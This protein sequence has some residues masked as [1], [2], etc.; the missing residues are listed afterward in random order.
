MMASSMHPFTQ[1]LVLLPLAAALTLGCEASSPSGATPASEGTKPS[2]L[3]ASGAT[4]KAA[5]P[6]PSAGERQAAS[7]PT[8]PGHAASAPGQPKKTATR[9]GGTKPDLEQGQKLYLKACANC[10]GP[11]G[12]G[13]VMRKML[14]SIGDHTSPALHARLKDEDIAHLIKKGKGKMPG[15]GEVFDPGQI[16][17]IIAYTRSLKK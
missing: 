13:R 3:S 4:A 15:F 5:T 14:P 10:H 2:G 11:D 6:T 8:H 17:A 16:E 7:A 9:T 12:S 1:T